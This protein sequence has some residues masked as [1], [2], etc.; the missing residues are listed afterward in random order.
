EDVS[1]RRA[2]EQAQREHTAELEKRVQERTRHL[3]Q[4][5]QS[6]NDARDQLVQVEK[7]AALARL[8][9]GMA[10]EVNTPI[11][12]ARLAVS[13]IAEAQRE[14]TNAMQTGLRRSDLNQFLSLAEDSHQLAER[15][16]ARVVELVSAF[17]QMSADQASSERRRFDLAKLIEEILRLLAPQLRRAS[18]EL[19]LELEPDLEMNS[20]A[21][22]LEQVI[23][24]LVQN[25]LLHGFDGLE[26]GRLTVQARRAKD[27]EGVE[28][29]IGDDG[30]GMSAEVLARA[31]DPFF[32]TKMGR[33]GLG[34]G[35]PIVQGLVQ[36]LLGGTLQVDSAPDQGTRVTLRLPLEG[37]GQ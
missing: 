30:R 15:N 31:F 11:G 9:A 6:L 22:P 37:P 28:L 35:L 36:K 12:N 13:T 5:I 33:G 34:L 32:T 23:V 26:S 4:T 8:V 3:A 19:V 20:Q 2:L 21:G 7:Q 24:N 29:V 25:A 14:F 18:C 16:L 27:C 17:K 10:H 1:E